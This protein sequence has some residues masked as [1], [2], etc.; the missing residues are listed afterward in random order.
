[1]WRTKDIGENGV[2]KGSVVGKDRIY[3]GTVDST[4]VVGHRTHKEEKWKIRLE[5]RWVP[6]DPE[7]CEPD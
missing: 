4:A 5:G 3:L 1:M 2:S 7:S 6:G